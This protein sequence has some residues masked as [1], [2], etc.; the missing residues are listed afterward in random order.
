M[1]HE[2]VF[3]SPFLRFLAKPEKVEP[4]G[5]LQRFPGQIG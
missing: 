5:I 4:V 1:L 2:G 3:D